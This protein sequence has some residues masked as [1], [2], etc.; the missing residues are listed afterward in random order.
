MAMAVAIDFATEH[1]NSQGISSASRLLAVQTH[2]TSRR[3]EVDA[4]LR[5]LLVIR[6]DLQLTQNYG[7]NKYG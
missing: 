3:C 2:L 1:G 5:S 7:Y 4:R 6:S